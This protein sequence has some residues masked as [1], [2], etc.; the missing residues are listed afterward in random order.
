M[1][2]D[3]T[4]V[5]TEHIGGVIRLMELHLLRFLHCCVCL[6]RANELPLRHL[7]KS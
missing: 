3:E 5:N 2:S 1:E 6:I 7:F 4:A